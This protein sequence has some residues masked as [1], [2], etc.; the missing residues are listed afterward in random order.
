M[1]NTAPSLKNKKDYKPYR[2]KTK[3]GY[4]LSLC[5]SALQKCIR[6]GLEKE[7]GYFAI[8]LIESGYINYLCQRLVI[9]SGEDL[10]DSQICI[11][12]LTLQQFVSNFK[13]EKKRNPDV[14]IIMRL[15]LDM[16]RAVKDREADD[17][18]IYTEEE[19]RKGWK[20][21]ITE[22]MEDFHTEEGKLRNPNLTKEEKVLLWKTVLTKVNKE[23]EG[24]KYKNTWQSY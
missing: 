14:N 8:E 21:E 13:K 20:P 23:K 9:I 22:W 5:V 3:N 15:I 11:H 16:C 6:R 1:S 18:K 17:F 12:A 2:P 19:R 24:N 4:S 10:G 7:A